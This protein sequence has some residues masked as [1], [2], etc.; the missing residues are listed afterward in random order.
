M[1][2]AAALLSGA[3]ASSVMAQSAGEKTFQQQ[4]GACHAVAV[5]APVPKKPVPTRV[6]LTVTPSIVLP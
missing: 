6:A 5:D 1:L 3:A 2:L 4:C